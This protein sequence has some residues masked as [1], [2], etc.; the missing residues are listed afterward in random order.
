MKLS[1][2]IYISTVIERPIFYRKP[3]KDAEIRKF[4]GGNNNDY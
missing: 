3:R 2:D 1:V 4:Q